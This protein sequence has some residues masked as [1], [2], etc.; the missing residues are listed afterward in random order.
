MIRV[1]K[2]GVLAMDN[3]SSRPGDWVRYT[4]IAYMKSEKQQGTKRSYLIVFL[5]LILLV[6]LWVCL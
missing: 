1:A 5:T 2:S 6:V 3:L 4:A